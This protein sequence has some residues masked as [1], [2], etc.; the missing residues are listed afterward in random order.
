VE[1]AL[2]RITQEALTNVARHAQASHARVELGPVGDGAVL[3][4]QD[5]GSGFP[6]EERPRKPGYGL[7]T[8]RERAESIGGT[9]EAGSAEGGGTLITVRLPS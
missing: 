5:D 1:L 2:F 8:M 9:F 6:D 4:I 7:I 3:T